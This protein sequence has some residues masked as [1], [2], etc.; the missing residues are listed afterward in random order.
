MT[1]LLALVLSLLLLASGCGSDDGGTATEPTDVDL[2]GTWRLT[3]GTASG[4]T[5]ALD[6]SHPV[7]LLVEGDR[8]SGVSACNNYMGQ[9]TVSGSSVTFG[10]LGGT[11]MA[12]MPSS[13]MA[14]EQAYLAALGTVD[15]GARDG[16]T[17]TLSGPGTTLTF[18][19]VP[20]VSDADLVGTRWTLDSLVEGSTVSSVQGKPATLD[21]AADGTASG[22]TGCRSFRGDWTLSGEQLTL[23][24]LATTMQ[25]C[26]EGLGAQDDLV[27]AVLTGPAEVTVEGS[28]LSLTLADGRGLMYRSE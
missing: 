26:P 2:S 20:P 18:E 14:L 3:S 11:Q 6:D 4:G 10:Q 22:S 17:L 25:A 7:T 16:D 23:P 5:L 8:V 19:P 28:S 9:V 21:L 1:R 24:A 12:C 13:V 15:T 27:L